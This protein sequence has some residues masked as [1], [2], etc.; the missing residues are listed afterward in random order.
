[1]CPPFSGGAPEKGANWQRV[2]LLVHCTRIWNLPTFVGN[3][4][5]D[6][7]FVRYHGDFYP[8]P[9]LLRE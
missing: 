6:D 1:M 9:S 3:E 2:G 7:P 8:H 4:G 5:N